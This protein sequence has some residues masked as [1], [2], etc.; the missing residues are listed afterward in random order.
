VS[1]GSFEIVVCALVAGGALGG[2]LV[3]TRLIFREGMAFVRR[4]CLLVFGL[5][6]MCMVAAA[7]TPPDLITMLMVAIPL[8]ALYGVGVGVWLVVRC[9][10]G[11]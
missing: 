5:P 11:R 6:V 9:R 10:K 8:C 2:Y 1:I 7:V 4:V 3:F